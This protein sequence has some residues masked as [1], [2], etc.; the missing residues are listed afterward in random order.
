[1][2]I[3]DRSLKGRE[4]NK[5]AIGARIEVVLTNG[6]S[7]HRTVSSGGSFG[8]NPLN[9]MIGLGKNKKIKEVKIYWPISGNYQ[10]LTDLKTDQW[11]EINET[12][13]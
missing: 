8:G 3:R 5:L 2:C 13:S 10:I 9:Q 4:T 11:H 6:P 7:I 12:D 1:M